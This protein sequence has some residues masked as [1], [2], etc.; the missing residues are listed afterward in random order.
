MA[1]TIE[2]EDA[3]ATERLGGDLARALKKGDVLALSGEIGAGKSTLA[4]SLIRAMADDAQLEVPSPTFTL[5]QEYKLRIPIVHFDFYRLTDP[6][7]AR[8]SSALKRRWKP[9]SV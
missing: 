1:V 6:D 2:L 8:A 4:R 7:E 5:A 3:A 9:Q